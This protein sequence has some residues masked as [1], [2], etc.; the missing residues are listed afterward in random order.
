MSLTPATGYIFSWYAED[1][2]VIHAFAMSPEN[3]TIHLIILNFTRYCY[4]EL[5]EDVDWD[6]A[7]HQRSLQSAIGNLSIEIHP[8]QMVVMKKHRLYQA[9]VIPTAEGYQR[10]LFPYLFVCFDTQKAMFD[11]TRRMTWGI[12]VDSLG[13]K[14]NMKCH[15]QDASP[16]LQLSVC[17][18]IPITGWVDFQGV[19]QS[20]DWNSSYCKHEYIVDWR[21]LTLSKNTALLKTLPKV[22]VLSFDWEANS[23]NHN[24][25]PNEKKPGDVLF[26]CSMTVFEHGSEKMEYHLLTLGQPDPAIVQGERKEKVHIHNFANEAD[27]L[28]GFAS[29]VIQIDPQ[30]I[31]GYN[32]MGWDFHYMTARA[33]L[34]NVYQSFSQ[35]GYL[36]G[37]S[38]KEK[39][40]SWSSSAFS[41]QNFSY[42]DVP[43][44]IIIDML[45]V[46]KRDFKMSSYSLSSVSAELLGANQTKDPLTPQGIFKCYKIH[47]PE[48][49]GVVGKYCLKD[50]EVTAYLFIKLKTWV[51]SCQMSA[52]MGVPIFALSTQGQQVKIYAQ[53]YRDCFLKNTVVE[54]NG[55]V[56]GKDESYTGAIVLDPIPGLHENVV[57]FDFASLYPST[58]IEKNICYSTW[59]TDEKI[60]DIDCH[61]LEWEDHINCPHDT[62]KRTDKKKVFCCKRRYRFLRKPL[63]IL[64]SILTRLTAERKKV[65]KELES[66]ELKAKE[67]KDTLLK[68]EYNMYATILDLTQLAIKLVSNSMYGV[69]GVREGRL[70]FM[71]GAM[72]TTAGGR[73]AIMKAKSIILEKFPGK[74]IYGDTD[75][76]M[77]IFDNTKDFLKPS[78]DG[79]E[80]KMD[81]EEFEKFCH[82]VSE[83][84]SSQFEKP[85]KLEFEN[86][87]ELFFL[88][89]KKRYISKL[90]NGKVKKRGIMLSRRDNAA[91]CRSVYEGLLKHIFAKSSLNTV[92][93]YIVEAMNKIYSYSFPSKDYAITKSIK[94]VS[95]YKVKPLDLDPTKRQKQL[96]NKFLPY[97]DPHNKEMTDRIE[98]EYKLRCLPAHVQLAETMR[99]RGNI[100]ESGSRF[101]FVVTTKG[102]PVAKMWQKIESLEYYTRHQGLITLDTNYYGKAL[103]NPF[104]EVLEVQFHLSGFVKKQHKLRLQKYMMLQELKQLLRPQL[105]AWT[106]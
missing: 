64:P 53:I 85:M 15:E 35:F 74:V 12:Y 102:G 28:E 42:P 11:F 73:A 54:K 43:G 51:G 58:I 6:N 77:Y 23:T 4:V 50:S 80:S 7:I 66:V 14:L 48:T 41:K 52:T 95:D 106:I 37:F 70:P 98:A 57:T 19:R 99:S 86:I 78:P 97:V 89:T 105:V 46:V 32:I 26:Q 59:V 67:E 71:P 13:R 103:I 84:I 91:C 55:Y 29:I 68:K 20:D 61:V 47:S 75:S 90:T 16:F 8:K 5:P 94:D 104:D 3:E 81:Y 22:R 21:T 33:K 96:A 63:G 40:I 45:P 69:M 38:A 24:R 60:P 30:I 39:T 87:A 36:K 93:E 88:L 72:S 101:A 10:K 18:D 83:T 25:M 17:R 92:L 1:D 62:V 79:K 2:G 76:L 82:L 65:K 100:V 44:R 9:H 34:L 31:T 49:L 27:I 56:C